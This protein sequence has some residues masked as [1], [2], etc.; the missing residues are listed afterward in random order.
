MIS[1]GY[2]YYDKREGKF[3]AHYCSALGLNAKQPIRHAYAFLY[4]ASALD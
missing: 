4:A 1:N 3:V 2:V